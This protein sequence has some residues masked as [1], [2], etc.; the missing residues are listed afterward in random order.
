V[1][2]AVAENPDAVDDYHA[3]EDG[4]LNFLVGQVMA[5]TGGSADPGTV[6]ELLREELA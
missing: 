6:N 5:A 1:A 2:T 3:G 4:A